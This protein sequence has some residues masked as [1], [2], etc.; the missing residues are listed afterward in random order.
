MRVR[1]D[2]A[3]TRSETADAVTVIVVGALAAIVV[4]AAAGMRAVDVFRPG[5]IAWTFDVDQV[6]IDA[7][8]DSETAGVQGFMTQAEVIAPGVNA[9]SVTA[10]VLSIVLGALAALLVIAA[11][12][13]VAFSLLRGRIFMPATA[14]AFDVIG[15]AIVLGA[16][17]VMFFDTLGRNGVLAALGAEDVGADLGAQFWAFAPAWAAGVSVGIVARAF[18]RGVR[19]QRETDLLV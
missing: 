4:V 2:A 3:S 17:A 9:V 19:L 5:G 11:V 16:A 6:P 1:Q 12:M 10:I 7:K 18:R 14:R 8:L 15:W 13:F